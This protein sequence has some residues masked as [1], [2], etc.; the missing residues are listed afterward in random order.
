MPNR[1]LAPVVRDYWCPINELMEGRENVM[2]KDIYGYVT[3]GIGHL[4]PNAASATKLPWI[5][6]NVP[7]T[8]AE[9]LSEYNR[10][11]VMADAKPADYRVTAKLR[12][13]DA[14]VTEMTLDRLDTF[15]KQLLAERFKNPAL[16]D[17]DYLPVPAQFV[18]MSIIWAVGVKGLTTGF[19]KFLAAV[20]ASDWITAAVESHIAE[21][22]KRGVQNPGLRPR[23]DLNYVFLMGIASGHL[24]IIQQ[25]MASGRVKAIIADAYKRPCSKTSPRRGGTAAQKTSPSK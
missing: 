10:V 1:Q 12:L 3:T 7:A 18:C 11:L 16:P 9:I 4:L 5:N 13:T 17:F 6:G 20:K 25:G 2:Y 15:Y 24:Q 19:P 21:I 23:N 8:R 14:A 22:D